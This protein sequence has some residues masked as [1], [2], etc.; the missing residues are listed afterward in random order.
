MCNTHTHTRLV[1]RVST[2]TNPQYLLFPLWF[3]HLCES[4]TTSTPR[5]SAFTGSERIPR[6]PFLPLYSTIP[7]IRVTE[8]STIRWEAGRHLG[9]AVSP[10]IGGHT[11]TIHSNTHV[12]S[13]VLEGRRYRCWLG[14]YLMTSSWTLVKNQRQ[15]VCVWHNNTV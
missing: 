7:V 12:I 14:V 1:W 6:K 9:R 4:C 11:H 2:R 15:R 5:S 8:G 13:T 3:K 10:L